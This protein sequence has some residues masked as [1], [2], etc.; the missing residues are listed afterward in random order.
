MDMHLFH[1]SDDL[2]LNLYTISMQATKNGMLRSEEL[3]KD[4][5]SQIKKNIFIG[6]Q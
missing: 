4:A 2:N 6:E 5:Q 3:D 1:V